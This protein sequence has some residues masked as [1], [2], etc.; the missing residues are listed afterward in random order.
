[1]DPRTVDEIMAQNFGIITDDINEEDKLMIWKEVQALAQHFLDEALCKEYFD[2][3]A[4]AKGCNAFL[5]KNDIVREIRKKQKNNTTELQTGNIKQFESIH[6]EVAW[7]GT[8][9]VQ[10]VAAACGMSAG[11]NINSQSSSSPLESILSNSVGKFG[12]EKDD[13]GPLEFDC[14]ACEYKNRRPYGKLIKFCQNS[15]CP[16]PE[17]I[18]C[19]NDK[20]HTSITK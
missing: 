8:K 5:V 12:V 10:Q 4:I 11:F 9:N 20:E 16:D 6:D 1:V 19:K 15:K 17:A 3:K 2:P 18:S 13:K 14:P 7:L